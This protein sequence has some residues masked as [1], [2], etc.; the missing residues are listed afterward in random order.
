[1]PASSG[2]MEHLEGCRLLNYDD[3]VESDHRAHAI[4]VDV[5]EC[6]QEEFS[7]WDN[8]NR[9]ILNPTKEVTE[10]FYRIH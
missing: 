9:V 8:I 6:F 1:M 2:T 3:I 5:E 4:E 10:T 7:R